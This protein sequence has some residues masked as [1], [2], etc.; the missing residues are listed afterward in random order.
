MKT[1]QC[2]K[3][4]GR[5]TRYKYPSHV[6]YCRAALDLHK[7]IETTA[8]EPSTV[9]RVSWETSNGESPKVVFCPCCGVNLGKV[10]AKNYGE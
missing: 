1:Y 7:T 10:L 6:K 9:H 2:K 8:V 5:F 4:H 3:C